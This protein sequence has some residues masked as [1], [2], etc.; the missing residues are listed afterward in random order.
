LLTGGSQE[1][2]MRAL[3]QQAEETPL[4][5]ALVAAYRAGGTLIAVGGSST[6]LASA[7][8]GGGGSDEALIYGTSPDPWYRGVVVQEGI[9]LFREGL[10]DQHF[11]SRHRL[12]RLLVSCLDEGAR[13]GFGLPE[14]AGLVSTG[15]GHRIQAIG[16]S[17][18]VVLDLRETT[19]T[20]QPHGFSAEN[21]QL[22][23]LK[24]GAAFDT[25]SGLICEGGRPDGL[26]VGDVLARF[27]A[28]AT[29]LPDDFPQ[30]QCSVDTLAVDDTTG[31][32]RF[33]ISVHRPLETRRAIREPDLRKA[34]KR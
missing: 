32:A 5:N 4:L 22:V 30:V 26:R 34:A 18:M 7:M 20:P 25:T 14:E 21:V 27:V 6:A 10:I 23:H 3:F 16:A 19:Y 15:G 11:T 1:R 9:G 8:I 28:E 33:N 24:P 13:Y 17:G 31:Q 29:R 2:L 12:G